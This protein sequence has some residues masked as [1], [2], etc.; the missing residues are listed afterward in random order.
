[1]RPRPPHLAAYRPVHATTPA[2]K[3]FEALD[4]GAVPVYFGA[5][6]VADLLPHPEAAIVLDTEDTP[7]MVARR[8]QQEA[9]DWARVSTLRHGWRRDHDRMANFAARRHAL[10][11]FGAGSEPSLDK[12]SRR[13]FGDRTELQLTPDTLGHPYRAERYFDPCRICDETYDAVRDLA[14]LPPRLLKPTGNEAADTPHSPL[15]TGRSEAKTRAPGRR[16]KDWQESEGV[17]EGNKVAD[18]VASHLSRGSAQAAEDLAR[19]CIATGGGGFNIY[20][21]LAVALRQLGREGE[22]AAVH[23]AYKASQSKMS[24]TPEMGSDNG[25]KRTK[26]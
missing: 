3:L 25:R 26:H 18:L 6:N 20:N 11:M 2:E 12:G 22:V 9:S 13:V 7:A 15:R 19:R 10:G 14:N 23:T 1:M 4:A 21:N 8:L 16:I 5:P 24:S 17:C